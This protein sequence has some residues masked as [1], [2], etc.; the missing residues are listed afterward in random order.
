MS[1]SAR[2]LTPQQ[3]EDIAEEKSNEAQPKTQTSHGSHTLVEGNRQGN[4]IP[5]EDTGT[6]PS[7][8]PGQ[9][10]RPRQGSPQDYQL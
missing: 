10:N 8:T 6:N 5:E 9:A 3:V 2:E 4:G 1:R 7:G